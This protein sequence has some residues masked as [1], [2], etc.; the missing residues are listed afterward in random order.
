[1]RMFIKGNNE[2]RYLYMGE[3]DRPKRSTE[4]ATR[5]CEEGVIHGRSSRD[6][7]DMIKQGRN[8]PDVKRWVACEYWYDE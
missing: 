3:S 7:D 6:R 1:M 5:T 2:H 8:G 4:K